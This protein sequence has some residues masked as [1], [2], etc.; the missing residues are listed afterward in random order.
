MNYMPMASN[1]SRIYRMKSLQNTHNNMKK[2]RNII[3]EILL[4]KH[5]KNL[6]GEDTYWNEKNEDIIVYIKE[7]EN[8]DA[9][10][11]NLYIDVIQKM[12]N[13]DGVF[14][15]ISTSFN[16]SLVVKLLLEGYVILSQRLY[17]NSK[18]YYS[19]IK[20]RK[21]RQYLSKYFMCAMLYAEYPILFLENIHEPKS[22]KRLMNKY[23]LVF[24]KDFDTI[25]D[26]CAEFHDE[27]WLSKPLRT[28]FKELHR[29]ESGRI[30]IVSFG[31]YRDDVLRAGEFGCMTG[32]MYVSYSGYHEESSAGSV[33]L[34]KMFQY[35]HD[36]GFKY[37]NMFGAGDTPQYKYKYRFGTVDVK[38]DDYIKLFRGLR[39]E[40]IIG[41]FTEK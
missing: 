26:R 38:R 10:K 19:G 2:K 4:K 12:D 41:E 15:C 21:K 33:Q 7:N 27:G 3:E 11:P 24:N 22:I 14:R 20:Q 35:L 36:H 40:N 18:I 39:K 31:L 32:E 8:Y 6:Q 23:E 17:V 13:Y 16:S 29:Q 34:L 5:L 28:C 30:K 37:C 9:V 25:I 1:H